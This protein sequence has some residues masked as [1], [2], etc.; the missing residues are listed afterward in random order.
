MLPD[1][2]FP[3]RR[4]APRTRQWT[5]ASRASSDR[6]CRMATDTSTEQ[7]RSLGLCRRRLRRCAYC[8]RTL[9]CATAPVKLLAGAAP[10]HGGSSSLRVSGRLQAATVQEMRAGEAWD[11]AGTSTVAL[12]WL[13]MCIQRSICLWCVRPRSLRIHRPPRSTNNV[14]T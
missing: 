4:K 14:V 10:L 3:L 1:T 9:L 12:A 5:E 7:E 8:L 11:S 13:R 6:R 2:V